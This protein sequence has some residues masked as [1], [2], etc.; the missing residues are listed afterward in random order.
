M[1]RKRRIHAYQQKICENRARDLG[2]TSALA[3]LPEVSM[4][5][6]SMP[7]RS[8]CIANPECET[9]QRNKRQILRDLVLPKIKGSRPP[10]V[11]PG[12]A[13]EAT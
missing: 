9:E 7:P 2:H 5:T 4:L 13:G 8:A 1:L 12:F 10:R 6:D 3:G 11:S